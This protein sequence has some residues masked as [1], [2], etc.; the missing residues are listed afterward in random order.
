MFR[1]ALLVLLFGSFAF[2]QS[3]NF[4]EL[5]YSDAID[6]YTQLEGE[7]DFKSDGL[8]IKYPKSTRELEYKNGSIHYEEGGKELTLSEIQEAQMVRYFEILRVLHSGDESEMEEMFE[9]K[10]SADEKTL[11]PTGSIKHY[12]K[13]IQLRKEK[14]ELRYIKLF[15]QNSDTISI[16]IDE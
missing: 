9:I 14:S 16:Q 15:L 3:Y 6:R 11:T 12:V 5:R 13:E 8:T 7:I 4:T 2:A 1:Q 10:G